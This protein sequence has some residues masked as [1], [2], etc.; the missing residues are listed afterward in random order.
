MGSPTSRAV[1][2]LC[3]VTRRSSNCHRLAS[4]RLA[5]ILQLGRTWSSQLICSH[6]LVLS[7]FSFMEVGGHIA[8]GQDLEFTIDLF[9]CAGAVILCHPDKKQVA[10]DEAVIRQMEVDGSLFKLAE[11]CGISEERVISSCTEGSGCAIVL[12][13]LT[14]ILHLIAFLTWTFPRK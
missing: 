8:V 4:W 1:S 12:I 3:Q 2:R 5:G 7:S 10:D 13:I 6:A 9:T 11:H 14:F